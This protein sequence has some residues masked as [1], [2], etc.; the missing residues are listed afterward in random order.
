LTGGF[1]AWEVELLP[2][3]DRATGLGAAGLGVGVAIAAPRQ[4]PRE[5]D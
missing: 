5:R 3:D 4:P 1:E 2:P